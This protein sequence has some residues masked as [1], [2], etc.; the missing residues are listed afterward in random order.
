MFKER[1]ICDVCDIALNVQEVKWR[2]PCTTTRLLFFLVCDDVMQNIIDNFEEVSKEE[3][4]K[5]ERPDRGVHCSVLCRRGTT[6][7]AYCTSY[8]NEFQRHTTHNY[9]KESERKY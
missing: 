9:S 5:A 8:I 2:L 3:T 7:L 6:L 4:P 1:K